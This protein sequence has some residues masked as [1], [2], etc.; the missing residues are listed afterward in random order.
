MKPQVWSE[1]PP[2]DGCH[3]LGKFQGKPQGSKDDKLTKVS[4][5]FPGDEEQGGGVR[6]AGHCPHHLWLLQGILQQVFSFSE[7]LKVKCHFFR[8][9]L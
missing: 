1:L 2:G 3:S 9:S 8:R 4:Q 7:V 6:V 5:N